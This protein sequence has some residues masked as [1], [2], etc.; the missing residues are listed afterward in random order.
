M[1]HNNAGKPPKMRGKPL[2]KGVREKWVRKGLSE[3]NQRNYLNLYFFPGEGFSL[4]I[5]DIRGLQTVH[6][7]FIPLQITLPLP[8]N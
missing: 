4:A 3:K 8:K 7:Q 2:G 1:T 6:F 5:W